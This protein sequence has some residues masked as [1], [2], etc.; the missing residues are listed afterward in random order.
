M[1][2]TFPLSADA[3]Y[4]FFKTKSEEDSL[5]IEMKKVS[6]RRRERIMRVS[7]F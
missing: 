5:K 4:R 6:R 3:A 7:F 1:L 2:A